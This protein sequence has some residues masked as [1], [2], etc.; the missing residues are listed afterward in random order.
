MAEYNK[1]QYN[2]TLYNAT[3]VAVA[4]PPRHPLI[5]YYLEVF[6]QAE[7]RIGRLPAWS[8]ALWTREANVPQTLKFDY[9]LNGQFASSLTTANNV[10]LYDGTGTVRGRFSIETPV[11]NMDGNIITCDCNGMMAQLADEI[12]ISFS[13]DGTDVN[14]II[15]NLLAL[16]NNPNEIRFGSVDADIGLETMSIEANG[17][18]VLAV[19]K[20]MRTELGG[21]MSVD[22]TNRRFKWQRKP[23]GLAGQRIELGKNLV[24]LTKTVDRAELCTRLYAY[25]AGE[26]SDTFLNLTDAGEPNEFI[27]SAAGISSFGI[28]ARLWKDDTI[29]DADDLLAAAQS[30]LSRYDTPRTSYAGG[31]IDLSLLVPGDNLIDEMLIGSEIALLN[32]NLSVDIITR[33][34]KIE[35]NLDKPELATLAFTDPD[36]G[37]VGIAGGENAVEDAV[38]DLLEDIIAD[39]QEQLSDL[40]IADNDFTA[41]VIDAVGGSGV[42]FDLSTDLPQSIG[43]ANVLGSTGEA[44]IAGHEHKGQIAIETAAPVDAP[45]GDDPLEWI[46]TGST[47][48]IKWRWN[49]SAWKNNSSWELS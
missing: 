23:G 26:D 45:T 31:V 7:V 15:V 48:T 34:A 29:T 22:P 9:P 10:R 44:V 41:S 43:T 46:Q 37:D 1:R 11:T 18:S 42:L 36:A 14:T 17:K 24:S 5:K 35:I 49:G 19:L 25:G 33:I 30:I 2:A 40:L 32:S 3:S 12:V 16:Q 28:I 38:E 47:P 4:V 13:E 20:D 6:T 27:D 8:N 21:Y 39:M